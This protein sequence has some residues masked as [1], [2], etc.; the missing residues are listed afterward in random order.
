[1]ILPK[2]MVKLFNIQYLKDFSYSKVSKNIYST[3][4]I[5]IDDKDFPDNQWTDFPFAVLSMWCET[6]IRGV[7]KKTNSK[8]ELPFMDGPYNIRCIKAQEDI[9]MLFLN[10]KEGEIIEQECIVTEGELINTI[11]ETSNHLIQLVKEYKFGKIKDIKQ[12]KK[13]LKQLKHFNR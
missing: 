4:Y 6:I 10:N 2:G 13:L 9:K 3:F 7:I 11:Y 5:H 1:M 12:L 8:F